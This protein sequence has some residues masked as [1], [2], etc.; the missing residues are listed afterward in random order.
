LTDGSLVYCVIPVYNRLPVTKQCLA[1][2]SAQDH[3]ALRVVIVD[4]ASTDGTR[5]YL[6]QCGIP[7]LTVL[8]GDGNLWWAGAM[9]MGIDYVLKVAA[10][11]DYLLMLNDD[12]RVG[13]D[14]VSTLV[15]D[16]VAFG[17]AVIGSPQRDEVTGELIECGYHIDYW[18]MRF[19][20]VRAADQTQSIDALPGRGVL[21]PIRAIRQAGNINAKAFPHYLADLEYSARISELGWRIRISKAADVY[22]S[23]ESSDDEIRAQGVAKEFLSFRSKNNLKQRLLFFSLRGPVWLRIWAVPRYLLFGGL[24]SIGRLRRAR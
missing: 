17:G 21:F 12:V 8:T 15:A 3:R 2:L 18:R 23:S 19:L 20:P 7:T 4:D 13:S 10:L 22:S 9:H 14:Y 5:E 24:R 6:A 11:G 16:S 1:Y